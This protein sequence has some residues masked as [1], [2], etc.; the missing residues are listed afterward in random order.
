MPW[1]P[2]AGVQ[3]DGEAA[4]QAQELLRHDGRLQGDADVHQV[5]CLRFEHNLLA[6]DR[7]HGSCINGSRRASDRHPSAF[8][9]PGAGGLSSARRADMA[10]A[11]SV[12]MRPSEQVG[13]D[14]ELLREGDQ[15]GARPRLRLAAD[16]L[17]ANVL[18]DHAGRA[19]GTSL[20]AVPKRGIEL[21]A[22]SRALLTPHA[23]A[24]HAGGEERAAV[25]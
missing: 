4:V 6:A 8:H 14:T 13:C 3:A 19:T 21:R 20:P 23:R 25:V 17:A 16:G 9:A 15:Q 24:M 11:H 18:R 10:T 2:P 12:S 5:S 22:S 7:R 1:C